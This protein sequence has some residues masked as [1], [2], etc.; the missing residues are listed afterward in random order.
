MSNN[1]VSSWPNL[2]KKSLPFLQSPAEGRLISTSIPAPG[3]NV[4]SILEQGEGQER[5]YW[6][7]D[8]KT[9]AGFGA[10][11]EM[12]AWGEDRFSKIQ[13]KSSALFDNAVFNRELG[14]IPLP[15]LFGGFA[16]R[17]DFTPDNTWA[18]FHPAHFIL[19]HY[20]YAKNGAESWLTI[21]A[22]IPLE[23]DPALARKELHEAVTARYISL[24][25]ASEQ[26]QST[27]KHTLINN[28]RYPM[29]YIS[30]AQIT[31]QAISKIKSSEL[32]KVVLAR[33][34]ELRSQTGIH[35]IEAL[36][37][38]NE[39][40]S[41][42]TR[43]LFE[44]RSHH[45]FYGA[46]P[47]LLVRVRGTELTTMALAGSRRRGSN[48]EED[49]ILMQDLLNSEKD[50]LE[51]R[52]VVNSILR[53]LKPAA[54][55]IDADV[56]P[57]VYTLSY[58]HHLLTE[59]SVTLHENSGVLPMVELLHPTSAL[60]GS[61][62]QEAL[63]LI[64]EVEPIP[65]GWYASPV[66][67]IDPNMDGEFCVAIRSAVAQERRVW[68]YAGAGIVAESQAEKEWAETELKFRPMLEAHGVT[69]NEQNRQTRISA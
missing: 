45:A 19:P 42:C 40:H 20:Q 47:E 50:Q 24:F 23:E 2:V 62:R 56:D 54:R 41:D 32:E 69:Q 52:L 46:S 16:F 65:R 67:W 18:V 33:A 28:I 36:H 6:Q 4:N 8:H 14:D 49:A 7:N 48:S 57:A 43:F 31:E 55:K 66:G 38:L 30:W 60:G 34:C 51:H 26:R 35:V 21:S 10:A 61:P 22:M 9:L 11:V 3:I 59:I 29:S 17:D 25:N 37:V 1:E 58:I 53:R 63:E 64:R 13:S 12:M 27:D 15:R 68:L 44:P 5:F 39:E